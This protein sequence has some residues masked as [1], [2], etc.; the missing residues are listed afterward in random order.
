MFKMFECRECGNDT[1][2]TYRIVVIDDKTGQKKYIR[3]TLCDRCYEKE[4]RFGGSR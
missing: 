4:M 3:K 2:Y 1:R